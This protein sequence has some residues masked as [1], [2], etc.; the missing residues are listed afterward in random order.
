VIE[1]ENALLHLLTR[2][3]GFHHH[4]IWW[5]GGLVD[6]FSSL[7]AKLGNGFVPIKP[8]SPRMSHSS[9]PGSK[10]A[11][12]G[13]LGASHEP[14]ATVIVCHCSRR[15]SEHALRGCRLM[16]WKNG[17]MGASTAKS[18]IDS[19]CEVL[20]EKAGP[21]I[22]RFLPHSCEEHS[23]PPHPR[24]RS[25]HPSPTTRPH[26]MMRRTSLDQ[27]SS[28]DKHLFPVP[29]ATGWVCGL[30]QCRLPLQL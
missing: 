2:R 17:R 16:R 21:Q 9:S 24:L 1:R 28:G 19:R 26:H 14:G 30:L 23:I 7:I 8:T 15:E 22:P 6:P 12:I 13:T 18:A 10:H 20:S 5:F 4:N 29:R 11:C 3:T 25:I 27:Q